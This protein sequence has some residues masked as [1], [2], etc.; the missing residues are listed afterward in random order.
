MRYN[1]RRM[2][3]ELRDMGIHSRP[4]QEKNP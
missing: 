4:R 1:M 3:I 2:K